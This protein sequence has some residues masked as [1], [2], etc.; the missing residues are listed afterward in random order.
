L[1]SFLKNSTNAF[2]SGFS[3]SAVFSTY[4]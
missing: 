2:T 3:V 1:P 4:M